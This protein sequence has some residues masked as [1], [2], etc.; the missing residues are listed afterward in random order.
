MT[1]E[2]GQLG[3]VMYTV[4]QVGNVI[5]CKVGQVGSVITCVDG[6]VCV[7]CGTEP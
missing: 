5:I 4:G 1:Y 3:N 2:V 6:C 7:A